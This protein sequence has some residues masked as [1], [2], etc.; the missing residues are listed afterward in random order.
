[1]TSVQLSVVQMGS[2]HLQPS[3]NIDQ[4]E[5][6]VAGESARGAGFVVFPELATT[7]YIEPAMPSE[8]FSPGVTGD[9][10]WP[11]FSPISL[12]FLQ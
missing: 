10:S 3:A 6:W 11:D 1:M 8:S 7:G 9:D 12:V 4:I 5:A 2:S